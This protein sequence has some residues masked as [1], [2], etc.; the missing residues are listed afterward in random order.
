[1]VMNKEEAIDAQYIV[2]NDGQ[3]CWDLYIHTGPLEP[4]GDLGLHL[5]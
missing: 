3:I 5:T 2:E 4:P 1:M